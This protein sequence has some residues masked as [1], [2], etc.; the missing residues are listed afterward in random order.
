MFKL[1]PARS[2]LRFCSGALLLAPALLMGGTSAA[3]AAQ[4]AMCDDINANY[5]NVVLAPGQS[6]PY[7]SYSSAQYKPGDQIVITVHD[8][9]ASVGSHWVQV[10]GQGNPGNPSDVN[11]IDGPGYA[12]ISDPGSVTATVTA[13]GNVNVS[14]TAT[15]TGG[16][17]APDFSFTITCTSAAPA[18]TPTADAVM[19]V[20]QQTH[21][22]LVARSI[23]VPGLQQRLGMVGGANP[24]TF[25]INP[26]YAGAQLNFATSLVQLQNF[27]AA[28]DAAHALANANPLDQPLNF[29]IDGSGS[30]HSRTA[31]GVDY[32]GNFGM[33]SLGADYL[34][35]TE[36][37]VGLA[38]HGDAMRDANITDTIS[39]RGVMAGPYIS[40]EITDDVYLDLAAYYGKSWNDVAIGAYSGTFDTQRLVLTGMLKGEMKL[41]DQLILRPNAT[42][43]YLREAAAAYTLTDGVGGTMAGSA[44]DQDQLRASL[45]SELLYRIELGDGQALIPRVGGNLGLLGTGGATHLFGN[46]STGLIYAPSDSA[47]IGASIEA[48]ADGTGLRSIGARATARVSF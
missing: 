14:I 31:A 8:S 30:I 17:L 47:N 27:G 7:R 25:G 9:P 40:A 43:F 12:N 22:A 26:N 15:V 46:A 33:L 39:G 10:G 19:N 2:A 35:S 48:A 3:A 21:S 1:F 13:N 20:V 42:L 36:L 44:Y 29:W 18:A 37:L 28:G 45:G 41:D 6:T 38:V 5:I 34:V 11:S 4:S 23:S 16:A 32:W 24:G